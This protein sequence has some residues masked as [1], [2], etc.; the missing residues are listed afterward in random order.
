MDI[1]LYFDDV[2][3]SFAYGYACRKLHADGYHL[4]DGDPDVYKFGF[5]HPD[6]HAHSDGHSHRDGIQHADGYSDGHGVTDGF[7]YPVADII[8]DE[9]FDADSVGY[10][11]SYMDIVA[12]WYM[13]IFDDININVVAYFDNV[14]YRDH[15]IYGNGFDDAYGVPHRKLYAY[16]SGV[17]DLL[18]DVHEHRHVHD[19][20]D[21]HHDG[22]FLQHANLVTV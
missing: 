5:A 16:D 4:D 17:A 9:V 22:Y 12:H 2:Q 19:D 14:Q 18:A 8:G 15:L 13:D 7:D 20:G 11:H 10:T 3:Y 6:C 21:A 1:V